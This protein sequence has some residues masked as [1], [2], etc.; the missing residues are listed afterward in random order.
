[1][2]WD[3]LL[4]GGGRNRIGATDTAFAA[5]RTQWDFD[6]LGQWAD[7]RESATHVAWVK[8]LWQ[9]LDPHLKGTA[10]VNHLA[11]DDAPEK[12]RAS[13]GENYR[14]CNG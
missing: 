2:T 6:L 8:A 7:E 13:F 14:G 10:Y 11:T 3:C 1:V 5:R 12:V 9:Q 4:C